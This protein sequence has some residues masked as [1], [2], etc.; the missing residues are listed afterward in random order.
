MKLELKK[1]A[2]AGQ[3]VTIII[4]TERRKDAS[5]GCRKSKNPMR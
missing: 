4:K 2:Q 1:M 5:Q 3:H